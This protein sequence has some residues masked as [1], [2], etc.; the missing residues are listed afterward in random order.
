MPSVLPGL[1]E[2]KKEKPPSRIEEMIAGMKSD[3]LAPQRL[4]EI[5]QVVWDNREV[6]GPMVPGAVTEIEHE[7]PLKAGVTGPVVAKGGEV[8]QEEYKE[9][10]KREQVAALVRMGVIK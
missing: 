4:R 6:L 10:W 8:K 9:T 5:A 1:D 7:I 2:E 3:K